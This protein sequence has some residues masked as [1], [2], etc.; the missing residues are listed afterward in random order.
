MQYVSE[1][2]IVQGGRIL[3][4]NAGAVQGLCSRSPPA[5]DWAHA[6]KLVDPG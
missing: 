4:A 6:N 5:C 3:A 2:I 1:I